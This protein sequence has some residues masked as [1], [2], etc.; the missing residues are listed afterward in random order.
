M[1]RLAD[2]RL[3]VILNFSP[4][5]PTF[6]LPTHVPCAGGELLIA[7]YEVDPAQDFELLRL[8][9]WEARVYRLG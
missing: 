9:P 7:N 2:D 5:R 8:R 6:A 1:R 4:D 3:L